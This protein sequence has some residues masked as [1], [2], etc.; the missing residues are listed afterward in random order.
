MTL[1]SRRAR[2]ARRTRRPRRL[3]L[4]AGVAAAPLL[5]A[6]C[7]G[8][9]GTGDLQYV[10]GMGNV[11]EIPE[12]DRG[13]PVDLSGESIQG[14]PLDLADSRGEVT[15]VNV[16]WSGCGPCRSEMPMLV[17]AADELD[18]TFVGINTRD[19]GIGTAEAFEKEVGVTYPSFYD[20]TAAPLLAFPAPYQ[21]QS[22]PSTVVLDEE[23]RVGALFS[24]EIPSALTL[25]QV[26]DGVRT[27]G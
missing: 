4:L 26:V 2:R 16:W 12:A 19:P 25:E 8:L 21:P 24:G 5:L 14:E 20:D 10:G 6:G 7:S 9:Q 13:E 18:A 3:A 11:V 15:V 27:D 23:G 17:E 22:M 1:A